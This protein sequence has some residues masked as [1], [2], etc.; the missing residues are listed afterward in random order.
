M[1]KTPSPLPTLWGGSEGGTARVASIETVFALKDRP[2]AELLQS[3][4]GGRVYSHSQKY[5]KMISS[6]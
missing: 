6:R 3:L 5:S 2:S 1:L 4:F